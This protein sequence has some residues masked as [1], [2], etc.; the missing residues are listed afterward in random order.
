[1]DINNS[2]LKINVQW[3]PVYGWEVLLQAG[4]EPG[5]ARS[6]GQRLTHWDTRAPTWLGGENIMRWNIDIINSN[7]EYH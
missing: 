7:Y 2:S 1:M 4:L 6:V 3:N 5:N